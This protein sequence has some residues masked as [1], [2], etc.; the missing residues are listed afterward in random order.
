MWKAR[1]LMTIFSAR[2]L[3]PDDEEE[4][5]RPPYRP[6]WR[7]AVI[8]LLLLAVLA[9]GVSVAATGVAQDA[10]GRVLGSAALALVPVGLWFVFSWWPER[11]V[12]HPRRGLLS[13]LLIS[14]LVGNGITAPVIESFI[15]PGRWLDTVS[16]ATR[17]AGF[18]LTVGMAIE[19]SKYLVLRYLAWPRYFERRVDA[20]AYSL[21]VSL[22]FATVFNLR[23]ALLEGG[24]QPGAAAIYVVSMALMQ[25][26]VGLPVAL[27]LMALKKGQARVFALPLYLLASAFLHG[28]FMA[29]R[30]GLVV[31][32]FGI[33]VTANA[34][35]GGLIF[36]VVVALGL[37]AMVA[38]LIAN[39]EQREMQ[40]AESPLGRRLF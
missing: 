12:Q 10:N 37:Y 39:A 3:P 23:F 32:G 14:F 31:P 5:Q 7:S 40:R 2:N 17:I 26:G 20:I 34:P 15:E 22:G 21:T 19:L 13:I 30:A 27:G 6:V 11:R 9:L 24:G 8:E 36:A 4:I 29:V 35:L 18:T 38:F 25:Q 28:L 16:G 33:G 1:L